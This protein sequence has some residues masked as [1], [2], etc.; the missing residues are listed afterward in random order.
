M[1][2]LNTL[3]AL[4]KALKSKAKWQKQADRTTFGS[5]LIYYVYIKNK[6]PSLIA[7][8][9]WEQTSAAY[10]QV[11]DMENKSIC[12]SNMALIWGHGLEKKKPNNHS[13]TID[14]KQMLAPFNFPG[15]STGADLIFATTRLT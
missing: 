12:N 6:K 13:Y 11:T 10:S 3:K 5:K 7:L 2:I 15:H 1:P 14:Q 4:R 9:L 8:I